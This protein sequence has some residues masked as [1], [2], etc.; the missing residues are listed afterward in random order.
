[1][2]DHDAQLA[3]ARFLARVAV[4]PGAD[5]AARVR[6]DGFA[7]YVD[8]ELDRL[9]GHAAGHSQLHEV[10]IEFWR[11]WFGVTDRAGAR[12]FERDVVRMHALG[13]YADLLRAS[14]RSHAM[15]ARDR[16]RWLADLADR[17]TRGVAAGEAELDEAQRCFSGWTANRGSGGLRYVA[18]QHDHGAKYVFG[19]AL[20]AGGGCSDGDVLI[21]WLASLPA[22]ARHVATALVR[23]FVGTAPRDLVDLAATVYMASHGNIAATLR[24]V[25]VSDRFY[26]SIGLDTALAG[27][28]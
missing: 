28:D 9:D 8:D 20:P 10:M 23:R 11:G 26:A 25:L 4:T 21:E 24:C 13:D 15:L 5:D 6:R 16:R 2:S 18:A 1:M 17:Q 7:A 22:T 14:A 19:M 12:R 27:R 3:I